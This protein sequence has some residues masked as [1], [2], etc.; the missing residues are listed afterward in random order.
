MFI[1][2]HFTNVVFI[3]GL[4]G[5]KNTFAYFKVTDESILHQL[6]ISLQ[7]LNSPH[8]HLFCLKGSY[9]LSSPIC[10][11]TYDENSACFVEVCVNIT[12]LVM[13]F[14]PPIALLFSPKCILSLKEKFNFSIS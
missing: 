1:K 3:L 14:I 10:V 11:M 6:N 8:F 7:L 5:N 2:C 9:S 13:H 12:S 4:C